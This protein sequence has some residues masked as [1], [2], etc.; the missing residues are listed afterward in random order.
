MLR[1]ETYQ[2]YSFKIKQEIINKVL[3]NGQSL[4]SVSLDHTLP[5]LK[6]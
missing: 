2:T 1:K 5:I 6:I 3:Q 4:V